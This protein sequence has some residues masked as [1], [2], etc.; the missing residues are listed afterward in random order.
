ME[1]LLL[2]LLL[3]AFRP[4]CLG[5]S[6]RR[7]SISIDGGNDDAV[8]NAN[9][10]DD[11]DDDWFL[12]FCLNNGDFNLK[13][14]NFDISCVITFCVDN[15]DVDDGDTIDA[16]DKDNDDVV[17]DNGNNCSCCNWFCCCFIKSFVEGGCGDK[18]ELFVCT[19]VRVIRSGNVI[20][21]KIKKK[22]K[23]NLCKANKIKSKM[24]KKN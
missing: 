13:L 2:L 20:S 10:D 9:D 15:D 16:D 14:V 4:C 19:V 12:E 8:L 11:N 23:Q 3:L 7:N 24:K 1:P 22:E 17:D 6:G 18:F 5:G 21:V